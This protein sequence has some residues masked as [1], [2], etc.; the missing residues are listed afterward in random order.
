MQHTRKK[1]V[2]HAEKSTTHS[3]KDMIMCLRVLIIVGNPSGIR[4]E[5]AENLEKKID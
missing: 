5:N 3:K 4:L 2:E 1:G